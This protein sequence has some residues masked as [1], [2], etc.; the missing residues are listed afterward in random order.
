MTMDRPPQPDLGK[1]MMNQALA[2]LAMVGVIAYFV[3]AGNIEPEETVSLEVT[4]GQTADA[5]PGQPIRLDVALKL[6]NNTKQ[7]IAL[8]V[9][10]QCDVFNWFLTG[11]DKEF[12]QSKK[13]DAP[14]AKQTVSTWLDANHTMN[15]TFTLE[16]DPARVKPGD[17]LLFL[18]YWGHEA[19]KEITIK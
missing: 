19:R 15:E 4:T 11:R 8:T 5:V 1:R 17:Y 6:A 14:C 12:V 18:R 9:P 13:E 7:G 3:Y 10:T 2:V 16:L